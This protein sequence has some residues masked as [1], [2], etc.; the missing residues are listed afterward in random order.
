MKDSHLTLRIPAELARALEGL[1][2]RQG[3]PKSQV[4]RAAVARYFA[5]APTRGASATLTAREL[6]ARWPELPRLEPREAEALGADIEAGRRALPEPED[7]WRSS[8]T[9]RS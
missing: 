2:K 1:A 5:P 6:A 7:R 9:R 8:S 3:V 4:V